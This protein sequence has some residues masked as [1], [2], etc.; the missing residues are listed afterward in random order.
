MSEGE[1]EI[2]AQ[3][4]VAL[5]ELGLGDASAAL[6]HIKRARELGYPEKLLRAA[7]ELGDLR[8]ML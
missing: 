3:Y 1:R 8:K 2:Y 7:P 5:A 4:Y 6:A